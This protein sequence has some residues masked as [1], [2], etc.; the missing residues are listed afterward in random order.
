MNHLIVL[1]QKKLAHWFLQ[2]NKKCIPANETQKILPQECCDAIK[3]QLLEHKINKSLDGKLKDSTCDSTEGCCCVAFS[4]DGN[5]IATTACNATLKIFDITQINNEYDTNA[6]LSET[7]SYIQKK[8][9]T[10]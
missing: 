3:K 8:L 2:S 1:I 5:K 6:N 10:I 4:P 9:K 7:V